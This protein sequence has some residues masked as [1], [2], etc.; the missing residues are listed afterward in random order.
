[1]RQRAG[2]RV[3]AVVAALA[4]MWGGSEGSC[5]LVAQEVVGLRQV[6]ESALV[7]HPALASA[8]AREVAA[9]AGVGEARAALLP[10][11]TATAVATRYEQPMV[12][13]PLHGFDPRFPPAF[14][15]TLYQ[16]HAGLDYTV[17]DGGAR[18]ARIRG[19]RAGAEAESEAALGARDAVIVEAVSSYLAVLTLRA[20]RGAHERRVGALE[21]EVTRAA[22][23]HDEGRAARV[24]VL[25]AEAALSQARAD[26]ETA[27]QRVQLAA[28]RLA[29]VA[30]WPEAELD[31]GS[32]VELAPSD[33]G[34]PER[35][36]VLGR[37][38]EAHPRLRVVTR[39]AEAAHAGLEAT[40]SVFL[41]RLALAGRY[42]AYGSPATSLEPEWHV[43]LQ[44]SYPV[45][46]G[47]ARSRAVERAA[48]EAAAARAEV[49]VAARQVE[50][51]VDAA[52]LAWRTARARAEALEAAVRQ[53]AEVAR[54]EAL[55]LEAGAGVQT[56][57][58]RAEAELLQARAGLADARHGVLEA[59]LRLAQVTGELTE[60]WVGFLEEAR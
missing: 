55:A 27:D 6:V 59:R 10:S 9:W 57:F 48:A 51:D 35:A 43:G 20:V 41:P 29:R 49:S 31:P 34:I 16:G 58:L 44:A 39:R 53:T 33:A 50:D 22:L 47:G 7:S 19:A 60:A 37:A 15:E 21:A 11:V 24:A 18:G 3:A 17:F 8:A 14:H 30:G 25:R 52:L 2:S 12:V 28:R 36:A 56:D 4:A 40:R 46:S 1:M 42:S 5:G 13:A 54:I 26:R 45:F 23:L 32:L 38:L